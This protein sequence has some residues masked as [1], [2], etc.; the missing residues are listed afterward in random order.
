[1]LNFCLILLL[2]NVI[3][4]APPR[5]NIWP[6]PQQILS[7]YHRN[8]SN[9]EDQSAGII[10]GWKNFHFSLSQ[11]TLPIEKQMME[12]AFARYQ[13]MIFYDRS[14]PNVT[15]SQ[16]KQLQLNC[17][18]GVSVI[19]EQKI[20]DLKL[21]YGVNES[22]RIEIKDGISEIRAP[23]VWG[24][25]RALETLSQMIQ[26]EKR[27]DLQILTYSFLGYKLPVKIIDSP[28]FHWR[29]FLIDTSRH[30]LTVR[31]IKHIIDSMSYI[32]LNVLHWHV[33]DSQSFP[34]EIPTFPKLS[35]KGAYTTSSVYTPE[36]V[37]EIVNYA[38]YRGIRVV[39]EYDMPGHCHS[40]SLGYPEMMVHCPD[41]YDIMNPYSDFTYKVIDG[42]I[43]HTSSVTI[44]DY[45]HIGGDEIDTGCWSE[46]KGVQEWMKKMG[47]TTISEVLAYFERNVIKIA[48]K[49]NKSILCWEDLLLKFNSTTVNLPK[50]TVVTAYYSRDSLPAIIKRGYRAILASGFYLDVQRPNGDLYYVFEDT[51]KT[52]Y[53]NDPFNTANYTKEEQDL[54]IGGEAHMWGEQVNIT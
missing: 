14:V 2:L 52:F 18:S 12:Q 13:E 28:R 42:V 51:W 29:G 35:E 15:I 38:F 21:E 6:Q 23:A 33:V 53:N 47:Y 31:K 5:V 49:Y 10:A 54:I 37:T 32:K 16:C 26:I 8:M 41:H 27:S 34:I 9:N 48:R 7:Q 22:Y 36:Q 3:L 25:L 4:A 45:I 19:I 50:E 24:A 39:I 40:W 17:I 1:M 43:S 30:Y 46:D 11:Y 20:S 44:D